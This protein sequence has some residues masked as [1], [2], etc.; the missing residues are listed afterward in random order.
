MED[1]DQGTILEFLTE[2][3][4]S[5]DSK[6][7]SIREE[8]NNIDLACG[9]EEIEHHFNTLADLMV[10]SEDVFEAMD[11]VAR[12]DAT[13]KTGHGESRQVSGFEPEPLGDIDAQLT[14]SDMMNIIR[15]EIDHKRVAGH[16]IDSMNS[17]NK[18][19]I[20]QIVTKVFVVEGRHKNVRDKTDE[21]RDI[22][23]F[24]YKVEF[25]DVNLT[26][27]TMIKYRSGTPQMLTPNVCR[28]TKATYSNPIYIDAKITATAIYKNGTTKVRTD[29]FKGHRIG[30]CPC[31]VRSDACNTAGSSRETLKKL[32]EDPTDPGGYFIIRGGEWTVDN[33]ENQ[34]NNTFHV[35]KNIH[36][37][38][39]A[40]GYFLS[41]PGD[42]F[43]NS[44]Q[45]LFRYLNS[46]S[47][48][49]E[50]TTMNKSDKLEIPF[51]LIFR[52]LGMTRD[53]DIVQ[54]IVYGVDNT[55]TITKQMLEILEKAF[56][57]D[58]NG[59]FGPICDS[60]NSA[61]IIEFI[62]QKMSDSTNLAVAKKDENIVKY[63]NANFLNNIDRFAF[64]HIGTGIEHRI[65]KLRFFGH[66]INKLLRVYLE[67]LEPTDRDSYKNKRGFAAGTSIAKAFKTDF[68]F[69]VVQE[70]K[71]QMAKDF[72]ATPFSQ[73]MF[74]DSIKRAITRDD[75]ERMLT[76]AIATGNK[77]ITV[78]R[79]EIN[80]RVSSQ[81]L[82]HKNDLNVKS[83]LGTINTPDTT[84]SKQNERADEMRRVHPTYLG[85]IDIS[86][87]ADSGEKVG[88]SKQMACT[89]SVCGATSSFI[90]KEILRNDGQIILLDD[91]LP[92]QITSE[93]LAKIF[94][95]GDWIGCCRHAHECARSYRNKRRHDR[96]HH[97]T[98]IVWEPL[99][100]E[101]SFWT[102]V[103]RLQRPLVIVYNNITAYNENWRN[104]DRTMQFKQWVKLTYD[105]IRG[106]RSKRLTMD[107]L[108]KERVVEYISPEE[109]ENTYIA[110]NID[111]LRANQNSLQHMY[112][113]C[114]IDQAIFGIITLASP[115]PD[116]SQASRNTMYT[117]H[118]KQSAGWFALNMPYRIDKGTTFQHY[119]EKPLISAFSD[120]LTHPNGQNTIVALLLHGGHNQEDSITV[121]QSS[122]D[123]GMFNA[124]FFNY[125]Q[126]ELGK[127]EVF[128]NPDM[129]RT[130][131]VKQ[132]S[133]Y[134]YVEGGLI[135]P[136][137][138]ARKNYVLAVKTAKLPKAI[139]QYTHVDRSI[140]Y[141][142]DEPVY[143]QQVITTRNDDNIPLAKIQTRANRPLGVG[144]KL[145]SRHGNKGIVAAKF[146]RCD[147]PYTED[148]II[149]DLLVNA[150]SIPTRMA[151]NQLIECMYSQL[152]VARGSLIDLTAFRKLDIDGT[153]TE[154]EKYGV[155]YGGHKRMYNG[156][157]GEW[158]DTLIFSGPTVYQR[159]QKFVIDE[160]YAT[161]DGPSSA[162]TRQ[163]LD[164]K[165]RDG[166]LR[167][168]EMEAWVLTA[169]G[170]G[171]SLH[172]KFYK[173]SDGQ[174]IHICRICMN[175]AVVNEKKG[176]YKCKYCGDGA[177]ICNIT[178]SWVANLF[179]NETSSMNIKMKFELDSLEY[180][181]HEN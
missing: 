136:G 1:T 86:Q 155:K 18:I 75:L 44:Y 80:N 19:G 55:D 85:Y 63:L 181:K 113:H 34:S 20:K 37:N 66:L 156:R 50:L 104:G 43:E 117:N 101:V 81:I 91:V 9:M 166:G 134:E 99:V 46:G 143:I 140:V 112:S 177:D 78:R 159:L 74:A 41:K 111:T 10:P 13:P 105:H 31:M 38:E 64:P 8:T 70:I 108:R 68:N 147:F 131:N 139:D 2:C 47:I 168:G 98:T 176:I 72:K 110:L 103:G 17:F 54:H 179:F 120:S 65:K 67:V 23:E 35:Y 148:G 132:N 150:H 96:I 90:L 40:R 42:A 180:P 69:A 62:A 160:H 88:M 28:L 138:I 154:L 24:T 4:Q 128:G 53:R 36:L 94:V 7:D 158:I 178:S 171:R 121:N 169:H 173:D 152:A 175:R 73:I 11:R 83:T 51:Y 57:S 6:H 127:G 149:P 102:D 26:P 119:C 109:Q 145:S 59:P 14:A 133:I 76:Q 100:R 21:D 135:K 82:Y 167:L 89:A 118:R 27:P 141:K 164:G 48:T 129:A 95:N 122:V 52:A 123:C 174:T 32:Q 124:S 5:A 126:T 144:D 142:K 153:L 71:K 92:E 87:S 56:K 115:S 39:I 137:T 114:D 3:E 84:A 12:E 146:P 106:L 165:V 130:M 58:G 79:N 45:I 125:E 97:L 60:T 162:L 157:T 25:T 15:A 170:G 77:T 161:R 16:H 29:E 172:E 163:P 49:I 30:S 107:D 22:S 151:V 61:R 116:H 33:L 93:K